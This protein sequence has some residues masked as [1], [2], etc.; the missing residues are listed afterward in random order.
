MDFQRLNE[1]VKLSID[2]ADQESLD[3]QV[4]FERKDCIMMLASAGGR[5][6]G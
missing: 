5:L 1:L 4:K 2:L 3:F 6:L